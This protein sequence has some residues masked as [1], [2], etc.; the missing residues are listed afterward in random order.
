MYLLRSS[1]DAAKLAKCCGGPDPRLPK[2][3][4]PGPRLV[5]G[6]M[7]G[8]SMGRRERGVGGEPSL[9]TPKDTWFSSRPSTL[10]MLERFPCGYRE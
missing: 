2:L 8:G 4:A 9:R 10:F 7:E 5:G 3:L 6:T 1:E